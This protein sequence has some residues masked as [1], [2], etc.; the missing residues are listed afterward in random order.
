MQGLVV[1]LVSRPQS[2]A[3][4]DALVLLGRSICVDDHT[5]NMSILPDVYSCG[6]PK[7]A[8]LGHSSPF[9]HISV[10]LV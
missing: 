1:P 7:P 2:R 6:A 3:R 5:C 8:L 4:S 9:L 10:S